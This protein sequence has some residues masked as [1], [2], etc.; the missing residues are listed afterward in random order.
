M[1][2]RRD[3]PGLHSSGPTS[4][5]HAGFQQHHHLHGPTN[6]NAAAANNNAI[7]NVNP[8]YIQQGGI[9]APASLR[10]M[11]NPSSSLAIGNANPNNSPQEGPASSP[12]PRNPLPPRMGMNMGFRSEPLKKKRGRPRKY[13]S[14]GVGLGLSP[15][16]PSSHSLSEKRARGSG[17]GSNK[18]VQMAALGSAGH[19]FTPHIITVAKGED[20]SK[21]ISEFLQQGPWAVCVLSANGTI[22]NVTLNTGMPT[23]TVTYEGRFEILSLSGSFV[24]T[25]A[26]GNQTRTGGLT[27]SLAGA[28]GSVVGG[29][30]GGLLIAASPVQVVV[31]TFLADAKKG[32]GR[33]ENSE[34]SGGTLPASISG[35]P[36]SPVAL[37]SRTEGFGGLRTDE[38]GYC[39]QTTG[40]GGYTLNSEMLNNMNMQSMDW[41]PQ[42]EAEGRSNAE[43]TMT[44]GS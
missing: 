7:S 34:P 32:F 15:L 3:F 20:V 10:Y 4:F 9:G 12:G 1:N 44:G 11:P 37:Q 5:L 27:V 40:G 35:R 8:F 17:S 22:S 26:G 24:L 2:E 28:D 19:G 21:K 33:T 29:V 42:F 31:G 25:E 6:L 14:D 41:G 43:A 38:G 36:P 13:S 16:T 39:E 23:G 30:V 18:K